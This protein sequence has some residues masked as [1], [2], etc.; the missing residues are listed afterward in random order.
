MISVF[1]FVS[2]WQF[3]VL[4]SQLKILQNHQ[5]QKTK[6]WIHSTKLHT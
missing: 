3:I 2:Q 5:Q 6:I 1:Y 4:T